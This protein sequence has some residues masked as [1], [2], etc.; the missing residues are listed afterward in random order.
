MYTCGSLTAPQCVGTATDAKT[1]NVQI[2]PTGQYCALMQAPFV[3][4]NIAN[5]S[6]ANIPNQDPIK[7]LAPGDYCNAD[8]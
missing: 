4:G 7:S 6:C 3:A 2:C 5:T 1:T 8:R